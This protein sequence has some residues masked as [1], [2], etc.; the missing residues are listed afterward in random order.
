MNESCSLDARPPNEAIS[1][2][3]PNHSIGRSYR[4]LDG[5][6]YR[7]NLIREC[8]SFRKAQPGLLPSVATPRVPDPDSKGR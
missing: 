3:C 6:W 2:P 5:D 8:S 1:T 4:Y 7:V